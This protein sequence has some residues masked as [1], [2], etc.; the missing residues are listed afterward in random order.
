MAL[1]AFK[2]MCFTSEKRFLP[3][4]LVEVARECLKIK[5]KD[6]HLS[7]NVWIVNKD[8]NHIIQFGS[9]SEAGEFVYGDTFMSGG[10]HLDKGVV[11]AGKYLSFSSNEKALKY[12]KNNHLQ[13]RFLF[14]L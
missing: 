12:I 5:G 1:L 14:A 10:L 3:P 8:T 6:H 2:G 9:V 4:S 13:L 11:M 7:R